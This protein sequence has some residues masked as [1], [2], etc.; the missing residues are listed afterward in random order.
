MSTTRASSKAARYAVPVAVIT[1]AVASVGLVPAL[2][3][4]GDPKLPKITAEE[5]VAKV[6]E[7]DVEQFSGTVKTRTSLGLPGENLQGLFQDFAG[8]AGAGAGGSGA[9]ADLDPSARLAALFQGENTLKVAVDGED[10]QRAT[11]VSDA[12]DY[13]FVH[14]QGTVWAYDAA[15]KTAF[16]ATAPDEDADEDADADT[17]TPGGS[18]DKTNPQQAAKELLDALEDTTTV[19]VDGTTRLAGRDAYQLALKP[20]NAPDSTVDSVRIA[21]DAKNGMPLKVSLESRDG[22]KPIG[23]IGFTS[24]DFG[25]PAASTFDFA[26][27]KGTKIVKPEDVDMEKDGNGSAHDA[28]PGLDAIPGLGDLAGI[29]G[30]AEGAEG[31]EDGKDGKDGK[32]IGEGWNS[33]LMIKGD[34]DAEGG[35]PEDGQVGDLV[36]AYTKKVK[37]DFGTGRVFSTRLVNTLITDDGTVY[38]GAVTKDGLIKAANANH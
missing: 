10:R 13:T 19:S 21:V 18:I 31:T 29:H 17:R 25:K 9:D 7:S 28:L 34:A 36:D 6:A 30:D 4:N 37:G 3:D 8:A 24:V 23:E 2:A 26:P 12:G 5:L 32:V 11:L 35:L 15:A 20:K 14:N 27:P 16:R 22:G 38:V 1:V 33:I